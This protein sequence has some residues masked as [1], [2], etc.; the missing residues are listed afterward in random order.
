MFKFIFYLF[1]VLAIIYEWWS[2]Y[3]YDRIIA[4]TNKVEKTP[5]DQI[6]N[7]LKTNETAFVVLTFLYMGW[8]FVGLVSSQWILFL[9]IIL[10]SVA[11]Q[12]LKK[13]KLWYQFDA[14]A[15]IVLL[16]VA[17]LN[18]YHWHINIGK[19]LLELF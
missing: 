1:G 10:L 2:L 6:A 5:K 15:T 8:L 3:H 7:N 13:D 19:K 4:L 11:N 16:V 12:W 18:T 17:I 14:I 9:T